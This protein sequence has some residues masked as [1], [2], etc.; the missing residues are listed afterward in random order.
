M[1]IEFIQ[2]KCVKCGRCAQV[3]PCGVI[4]MKD[5]QMAAIREKNC[6]G[7]RHCF[8]V[9]PA[10]AIVFDGEIP[11]PA[12]AAKLPDPEEVLALMERRY[13]CREY[14]NE[15]ISPDK[16]AMLRRVLDCSPTGCNSRGCKYA[17][18][19]T[20]EETGKFRDELYERLAAL[21][22]DVVKADATLRTLA[23]MRRRGGDPILRGAPGVV[24]AC[25]EATAATGYVDAVIG[26]S[27]FETMAQALGLGTCWC[28]FLANSSGTLWPGL[29][30]EL[31]LGANLTTAYAMLFGEKAFGYARPCR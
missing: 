18:L 24:V 3:C 14:K 2:S 22:P 11:V 5:G 20:P 28:G 26:L 29:P 13:S 23:I 6:M 16:L 4:G 17:I 30:A 12:S 31:G 27:K 15:P 21:P 7:C 1:A 10:G 9:C 19:A 8:G 25:Y